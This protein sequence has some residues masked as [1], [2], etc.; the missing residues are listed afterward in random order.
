M[1][2]TSGQ[3][4]EFGRC[5]PPVAAATEGW[6]VMVLGAD[7]SRGRISGSGVRRREATRWRSSACSRGSPGRLE[8]GDPVALRVRSTWPPGSHPHL[9]GPGLGCGGLSGLGR[10]TYFKRPWRPS[11]R[12]LGERSH[13]GRGRGGGREPRPE[14]R[15]FHV[16]TESHHPPGPTSRSVS[17]P[18][19]SPSISPAPPSATPCNR[20][21]GDQKDPAS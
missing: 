4:H 10:S 7:L 14:W 21:D 16:K 6:R 17:P 1:G 2:T 9:G 13:P 15:L 18:A 19:A 8:A 5:L 12:G 3:V 11:V 20:R